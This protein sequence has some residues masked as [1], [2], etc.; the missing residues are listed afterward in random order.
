SGNRAPNVDDYLGNFGPRVG[1]AYSPNQG[2]T[3]IRAAFGISYWN[4][5]S[6]GINVFLE[7]NFPLFQTFSLG[8]TV[9]YVPF[10][11]VDTDGLPNFVPT[12]ITEHIDPIAGISPLSMPRDYR[13][14][15]I[16]SW[17]GGI[18]QRLGET[19]VGEIAYVATRGTHLD[20]QRA[21]NTPLY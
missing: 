9:S 19:G 2:R 3:A 20:R 5:N 15:M 17:N 8:P 21:I 4:A 1:L 11:K 16:L 7:R 14:A 10:L 6:P 12:P 13:P 18:Q